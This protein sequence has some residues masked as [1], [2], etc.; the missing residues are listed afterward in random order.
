MKRLVVVPLLL[1]VLN[2]MLWL[3]A[4]DFERVPPEDEAIV[5]VNA[6]LW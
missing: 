2:C 3:T 5:L 6:Y 4:C 1:V